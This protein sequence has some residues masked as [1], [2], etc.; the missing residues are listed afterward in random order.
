MGGGDD[1]NNMRG[2]VSVCECVCVCMYLYVYVC[3]CT[4]IYTYRLIY[5]CIYKFVCMHTSFV[6]CYMYVLRFNKMLL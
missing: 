3:I 2:R 5:V 1:I 4:D 6:L